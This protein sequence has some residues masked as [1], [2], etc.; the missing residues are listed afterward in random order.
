[1]SMQHSFSPGIFTKRIILGSILAAGALAGLGCETSSQPEPVVVGGGVDIGVSQEYYD[2]GGYVGDS[3]VWHDQQGREMRET[4][5][6]HENRTHAKAKPQAEHHD[7][8]QD[9][10]DEHK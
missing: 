3:W 1:M 2:R 10:H 6:V 7:E 4:R 8:H 5:T 9:S